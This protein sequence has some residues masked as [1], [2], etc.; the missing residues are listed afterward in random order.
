MP[1][2]AVL[3]KLSPQATMVLLTR[4]SEK[5]QLLPRTAPLQKGRLEE[6]PEQTDSQGTVAAAETR[7]ALRRCDPG[8]LRHLPQPLTQ[9]AA[10]LRP[11]T[12]PS[13]CWLLTELQQPPTQS[14]TV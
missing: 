1:I 12:P 3:L 11:P 8:H 9:P 14:P 13:A 7:D 2:S 10:Q 6:V 4:T 5:V